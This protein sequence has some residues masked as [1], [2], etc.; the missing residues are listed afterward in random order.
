MPEVT[1][2]EREESKE[3]EVRLLQRLKAEKSKELTANDLREKLENKKFKMLGS[4]AEGVKVEAKEG[5]R[6]V[7]P[8]CSNK[9]TDDDALLQHMKMSH[10]REMF[11][12]SKC[13][14]ESQPAIG[15]SVEVLLQ[16]LASSHHLNVSI[17][18]AISS[19]LAIP[20]SLHKVSCKLCP[21]P[22]MLGSPGF[23][24]GGDVA[25]HMVAI[26]EHFAT[27][28]LLTENRE[29]LANL[30]LAC[31]GCDFSLPHSGRQDW[32]VHMRR[33]HA[34][35]NRPSSLA[36]RT[37]PRKRC[38][39]C[40]EQVVVTEAVRHVREVHAK[41]VFQCKLCLA[42]DPTCFPH[43]ET[44]KEMT[45]HMVL[46]H[47]DQVDSYYDHMVYP[48]TLYGASCSAAACQDSSRIVAFDALA[49]G[50]HLREHQDGGIRSSSGLEA[51]TYF[52]RCCDRVK[53]T[54]QTLAM[55]QAHIE[56]RHKQVLRWRET[57][58]NS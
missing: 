58:G 51:A 43:A 45:A 25:E 49:I 21:P 27:V 20:E 30:E 2:E 23:W 31:R 14:K 18:E 5:V 50:R 24:V 47:G 19:F 34:R 29:V 28:H 54:F 36:S 15:W 12:C 11:G 41:E 13:S 16:H 55:V 8:F 26:E 32:L 10:R 57:N 22:H 39:F 4:R 46:R 37:G 3:D 9:F 17:S 52:C 38:D 48:V 56:K 42:Q 40:G 7:C 6:R 44:I 33:N 1:Q 35:L 53:E